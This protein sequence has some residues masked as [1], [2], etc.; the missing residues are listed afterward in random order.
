MQNLTLPI[1]L[2]LKSKMKFKIVK[3]RERKGKRV[4]LGRSLKGHL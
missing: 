2:K 3:L 4:D 1:L